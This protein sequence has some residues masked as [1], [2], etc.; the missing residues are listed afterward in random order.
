[1][2][3]AGDLEDIRKTLATYTM[4]GDRLRLEALAETFSEDGLFEIPSGS[5]RGRQAIIDGLRN[6]G[7]NRRPDPA[8][9]PR[10]FTR[11]SLTTCDIE[12]TS[13]NSATC[14]TYFV[15]YSAIGPDH[16]GVYDDRL[17]RE[18]GRWRFAYRRVRVDWIHDDTVLPNL[19][20][21]LV[22]GASSDP[23]PV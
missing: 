23:A 4:N 10:I 12:L 9:H 22:G 19:R 5:Y 21:V 13:E 20:A 6:G 18:G 15:V 14:R 17:V 3:R 8:R 7:G 1:M 16:A 11:H 2:S